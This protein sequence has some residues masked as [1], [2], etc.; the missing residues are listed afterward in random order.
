MKSE[1][2]KIYH[3][4]RLIKELIRIDKSRYGHLETRSD[5]IKE[6]INMEYNIQF[7]IS[8]LTYQLYSSFGTEEPSKESLIKIQL[9]IDEL[10]NQIKNS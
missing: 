2:D 1:L 3:E 9:K 4:R 8:Q 7:Q 5:E 10:R 6:K